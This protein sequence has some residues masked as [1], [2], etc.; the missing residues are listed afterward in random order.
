M[1]G[2]NCGTGEISSLT[3]CR[4]CGTFLPDFENTARKEIPIEV[5]LTANS[6]LAIMTAAVSLVLAIDVLY[7]FLNRV[8]VPWVVYPVAGFLFAITAWQMRTYV[9]TRIMKK[10]IGMLRPKLEARPISATKLNAANFDD[11]VPTR[12]TERTTTKIS[13]PN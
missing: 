12:M 1:F 4:K 13:I 6:F 5:H 10:Q 11:I 9:R 3:Y 7:T 8:D 2:P